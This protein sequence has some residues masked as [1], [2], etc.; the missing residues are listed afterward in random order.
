MKF[1]R[2][3]AAHLHYPR[4]KGVRGA[5]SNPWSVEDLLT[6]TTDASGVTAFRC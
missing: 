4:R 2:A 1:V 3:L 5:G 6:S